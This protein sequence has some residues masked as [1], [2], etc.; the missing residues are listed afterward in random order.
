MAYSDLREF[1]SALEKAGEL[2]R[3]SIEVDSELE[4]TEFADRSV[5]NGGP[6]LLFEKPKGSNVPLLVNAFA[7]ERR[8]Q[9]ALEVDSVEEIAA[10][11]GAGAAVEWLPQ[12]TILFDGARL[13]RRHHVAQRAQALVDRLRLLQVFAGIFQVVGRCVQGARRSAALQRVHLR[14]QL[15]HQRRQPCD[16]RARLAAV[17]RLHL[18]AVDA[19]L[20]R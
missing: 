19:G 6:A 11:I 5:K 4:I 3:V 2:K 12:E 15:G 10:R 18:G 16:L 13:Q 20:A 9:I 17:E 1:I 8:M 14:L 7:S